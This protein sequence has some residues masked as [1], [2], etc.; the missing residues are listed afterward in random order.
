MSSSMKRQT[1]P[2]A[3]SI[4]AFR[5]AA[6]PPLASS[7]QPQ[8]ERA[9]RAAS[10]IA[11][12]PSLEPSSATITSKPAGSALCAASESR[13]RRSTRVAVVA[14]D[15]DAQLGRRGGAHADALGT[16]SPPAVRAAGQ[17]CAHRRAVDA[18]AHRRAR[19]RTGATKCSQII[20]RPSPGQQAAERGQQERRD[21]QGDQRPG[22]AASSTGPA[23]SAP[24]QQ[25]GRAHR[26]IGATSS[27]WIRALATL[28]SASMRRP[29]RFWSSWMPW[30]RGQ[31]ARACSRRRS[32]R[33]P[34]SKSSA[35]GRS[36][37]KP[38]TSRRAGRGKEKLAP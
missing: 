3:A 15:D 32:S 29:L 4:A 22:A 16:R 21:A 24:V 27:T 28:A 2:A 12:V 35:A 7:Q 9:S 38:P 31:E 36:V 26:G 23:P 18:F 5:A 6:L 33:K 30:A 11:A 1:A 25:L 19:R 14:G 8:R 34:M 10:T 13:Q 37:A 17:P 20:L